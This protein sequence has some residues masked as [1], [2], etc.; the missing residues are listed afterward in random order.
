MPGWIGDGVRLPRRAP[1]ARGAP[2]RL[3]DRA[4]AGARAS[5]PGRPPSPPGCSWSTRTGPSPSRS[6]QGGTAPAPDNRVAEP[7]SRLGWVVHG[8]VRGGPRA[9][10]R[11]P[12]LRLGPRRL[13]HPAPAAGDPVSDLRRRRLGR[14]RR[15]HRRRHE[16]RLH[17]GRHARRGRRR[18]R[19]GVGPRGPLR[20]REPGRGRAQGDPPRPEHAHLRQG[21]EAPRDRR[22]RDQPHRGRQQP[23]PAGPQGRD[24]RDR[25]QALLRATTA[26]TTTAC[27]GAAVR[28][29]QSGSA[30][31][32]G[33]TITMQLIKNLYDPPGGPH[34]LE[35]DRGGVPRLPVR[36]AVHE[37]RD[38]HAL[39]ERRLLRPERRRACRRRRSPTSTRDV[40]KINLPQAALLAGPAAGPD[41]LQPVHQP[42]DGAGAAQPGARR[43]GRPGLHHPGARRP[44]QD[45]RAGAEA[46]E[47]LQAQARGVLLRVRPPA[48]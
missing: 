1:L 5:G 22:G 8:R 42:R 39:P 7:R 48:C 15:A 34:D 19:A 38:P 33:S 44:G 27:A 41:L 45:G 10:D 31:Q 32:G 26:S 35:E 20:G 37:G 21:Q 14:R 13:E 46:R 43:D 29:L 25:G 2:R 16:P 11:A 17:R 47:G 30:S 24:R 36:E 23:H 6:P 4:G 28:D 3:R 9:D 40:S 12:R 18:L